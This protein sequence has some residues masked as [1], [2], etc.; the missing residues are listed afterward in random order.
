MRERYNPFEHQFN[1]IHDHN[2]RI[3][4]AIRDFDNL[5]DWKKFMKDRAEDLAVFDK[6]QLKRIQVSIETGEN[7]CD[8]VE[9]I[10]KDGHVACK[11]KLFSSVNLFGF[12]DLLLLDRIDEALPPKLQLEQIESDFTKAK[13]W[14]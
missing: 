5:I 9:S 10:I 12:L 13:E 4:E 6:L 8:L 2:T 11:R 7:I 1:I 3:N 14:I